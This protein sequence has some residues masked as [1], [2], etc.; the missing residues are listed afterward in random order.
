VGWEM[1]V[2]T[3]TGESSESAGHL[4]HVV[5]FQPDSSCVKTSFPLANQELIRSLA[6]RNL[7]T[8]VFLAEGTFGD[9]WNSE[10]W[11]AEMI[12]GYLGSFSIIPRIFIGRIR[13]S[14]V[15]V[16]QTF[17][18]SAR[19][20]GAGGS[21]SSRPAWSTEWVP[22]QPGLHRETLSHNKTKQQQKWKRRRRRRKR[23]KDQSQRSGVTISKV[24]NDIVQSLGLQAAVEEASG[25]GILLSW[26]QR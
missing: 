2:H 8:V 16:E 26:L 11:N 4:S 13:I 20:S 15:G 22:G 6:F 14:Q 7:S 23:N 25:K 12:L 9:V 24:W 21:L 3:F 5:P 1:S 17:N 19:G 18:P 10:I